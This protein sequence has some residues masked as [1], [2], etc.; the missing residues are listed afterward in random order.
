[1]TV[2]FHGYLNLSQKTIPFRMYSAQQW[3]SSQKN[4]IYEYSYN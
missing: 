1:M 3:R 4:K 2:N